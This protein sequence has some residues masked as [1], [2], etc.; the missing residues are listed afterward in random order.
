M[1]HAILM[2]DGVCYLCNWLVRFALKWD[3]GKRL[4]FASLQSAAGQ[5]LLSTYAVPAEEIDSAILIEDGQISFRSTCALRVL[6]YLRFP[7]PLLYGLIV[8]PP[9]F[10]DAVYDFVAGKRYAWFGRMDACP[11]PP[12]D[13][14]ER[15][16]D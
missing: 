14:R 6:R 4:R 8:I 11:I 2:Y 3:S 9:F 12:S 10:R 1:D 15:F 13:V 5:E 16:L 7:W